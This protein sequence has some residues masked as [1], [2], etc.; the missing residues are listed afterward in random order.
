MKSLVKYASVCIFIFTMSIDTVAQ[1]TEGTLKTNIT[2]LF[3]LSKLKSF[4][5]AALLIAY[6]GE[7]NTRSQKDTFNPA[8]KEELTQVK[9]ICKKI[10]AL[11][12]LS[13]R[14]EFGQYS[15]S[16]VGEKDIFSIDVNFISGD[17]KLV[18]A[19]SFIQ[20][21]KGFLLSNMN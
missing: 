15:T 7:D 20:T 19:F 14:Y 9:R 3:D 12:E 5:K 16:R 6:E 4:E 18:T 1:N 10:S 13:T 8:N 2:S 11:I 21:E 17:Q